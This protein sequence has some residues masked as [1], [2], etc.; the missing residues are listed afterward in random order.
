M[1]AF[2]IMKGEDHNKQVAKRPLASHKIRMAVK[3][4]EGV[5]S[6]IEGKVGLIAKRFFTRLN[7]SNPQSICFLPWWCSLSTLLCPLFHFTFNLKSSVGKCNSNNNNNVKDNQSMGPT[8]WAYFSFKGPELLATFEIGPPSHYQ[9]TTL[10]PNLPLAFCVRPGRSLSLSL[11]H[12]S[13]QLHYQIIIGDF[14]SSI[15]F[16]FPLKLKPGHYTSTKR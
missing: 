13:L 7:H 6:L 16:S 2:K 4:R 10:P 9:F 14:N 15:E 8:H 12:W 3:E 11:S 5:L 1:L